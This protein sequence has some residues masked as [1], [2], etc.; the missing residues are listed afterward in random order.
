MQSLTPQIIGGINILS[1]AFDSWVVEFRIPIGDLLDQK[2]L[3][4]HLRSVKQEIASTQTTLE[5]SLMFDC[6]LRK[7]MVDECVDVVVRIKKRAIVK[8]A[9]TITLKEETSVAGVQYSNMTAHI[10]IF[11]Y[12]EFEQQITHERLRRA[13]RSAGIVPELL[14]DDILNQKFL[15]VCDTQMPCRAIPVARGVLPETGN[16]AE[17]IFYFQAV[18]SSDNIEEMVSS[19]RV[20]KGDLLCR[21]VPPTLGATE[22]VNVLGQ[23][24]PPRSGLDIA[25][26][27]GTNVVLSLDGLDVVAD[28]EGLVVVTRETRRIKFLG[29]LKEVPVTVKVKV[30]PVLKIVGNEIVDLSTPHAVEIVGNLCVGSKILSDSE[31]YVSGNVEEG[32]SISAGDDVFVTGEVTKAIVTSQG[33]INTGSSVVESNIHAHG[34]VTI[35]GNAIGS[36]ISGDAVNVGEVSGSKI[37]ARQ[38]V[39]L[40][41]INADE[42]SILS[43]ICVGMQEFFVQRLRENQT[44]LES[45]HTNLERIRA[46][47]GD[48]VFEKVTATNIQTMLMKVLSRLRMDANPLKRKQVDIYRQLVETIPPTRALVVQKEQECREIALRLTEGAQESEGVIIVKERISSKLIASINGLQGTVSEV[49]HGAKITRSGDRIVVS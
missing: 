34:D 42:N 22:G 3:L 44:F 41:Q 39:T 49:D 11:F 15:E 5:E 24:L 14:D 26:E 45:A 6:I 23:R 38:S 43:T 18:S 20:K 8:G 27:A 48:E 25:I 46:V 4:L 17:V 1:Q 29:G 28:A 9:P 33:N 13:I 10:D 2:Q 37:I 36:S 32:A 40:R 16:D 12:D 21:K 35:Q 31:V 19:R 30:D 7:T 47:V